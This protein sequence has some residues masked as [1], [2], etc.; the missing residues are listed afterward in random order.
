VDTR[1][2]TDASS[3]I[4][5]VPLDVVKGFRVTVLTVVTVGGENVVKVAVGL[6][7]ATNTHAQEYMYFRC[8]HLLLARQIESHRNN[9]TQLS[10]SSPSSKQ[11]C[12]RDLTD[13]SVLLST[14]FEQDY[15]SLK[16]CVECSC[17]YA[18]LHWNNNKLECGPMPNVVVA[19]PN[20]RT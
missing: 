3:V 7:S 16:H 19:L 1:K 11:Q 12:I 14:N 5:K 9:S 15:W 2:N 6:L 18:T 4:T 8:S 17:W 13:T 20:I 10:C